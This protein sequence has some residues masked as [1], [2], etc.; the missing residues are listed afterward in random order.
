[1]NRPGCPG[2]VDPCPVA[3]W[4]AHAAVQDRLRSLVS[5]LLVLLVLGCISG[6]G[7]AQTFIVTTVADSVDSTPG[8][9]SCV[10]A[11]GGCSL[12]AAIMEA[13]ALEGRQRVVVGAGT[14]TLSVPGATENGSASGDLD[15]LDDLDLIGA[16]AD[17]S[18]V[19][20]AGVDRAFDIAP[21]GSGP[22]SVTMVGLTVTGGFRISPPNDA[23]GGGIRVGTAGSLELVEAVV[24]D[25]LADARG[26]GIL[27]R[28]QLIIRRSRIENN[29]LSNAPNQRAVGAGLATGGMA[30][31]A[32]LIDTTVRGNH[33]RLRGYG[34]GVAAITGGRNGVHSPTGWGDLVIERSALIDN[35]AGL[36]GAIY[37]DAPGTLLLQSSTISGNE[38]N[39]GAGLFLQRERSTRIVYSTITDNTATVLGGGI[40]NLHGPAEPFLRVQGSIVA[41]NLPSDLRGPAWSEGH[42]LVTIDEGAPRWQPATGDRPG[43][44]A[45]LGEL[46]WP[47][48]GAPYHLPEPDSPVVD[49][50]GGGC[51]ATDQRGQPR[52]RDGDGDGVVACDIGA[53]ELA[54]ADGLFANGFEP[55]GQAHGHPI[56]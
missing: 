30:S 14:H 24:R 32:W 13:N 4:P 16:G 55:S 7:W 42:N 41:D 8:D 39:K 43:S 45:K 37:T 34:G 28:G 17:L 40:V 23:E 44:S 15:I 51:P 20:A 46:Q 52:P 36:G 54:L 1:M 47:E 48:A 33:A 35:R 26:G 11:S 56:P 27:N 3:P 50:G 53:I 31:S 6:Q 21:A 22:V 10:D 38:A 29:S 5:C 9:G 25:N 2:A 19:D 12:R 18:I 49:T